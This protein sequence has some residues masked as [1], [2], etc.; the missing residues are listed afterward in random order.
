MSACTS[1]PVPSPG[2]SMW[3]HALLLAAVLVAS[4]AQA[5]ARP[6]SPD[7]EEVGPGVTQPRSPAAEQSPPAETSSEAP[8]A[9]TGTPPTPTADTVQIP[10]FLEGS[11]PE[12]PAGVS[13]TRPAEVKLR[14]TV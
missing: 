10:I 14:I 11:A 8:A 6:Q 7:T 2:A 13:L 3:P 1:R 12:L 4:S 5:Q 9:S